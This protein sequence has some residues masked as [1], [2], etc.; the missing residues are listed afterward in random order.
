VQEEMAHATRFL[1][2]EMG[3]DLKDESKS[4]VPINF[5][6]QEIETY[7]QRFR[8]LD[9]GNKGYITINDLRAYF[10][11]NIWPFCVQCFTLKSLV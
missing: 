6:K 8:A 3:L 4:T 11:V 10:K 2:L 7:I 9:Q 1:R 5:N